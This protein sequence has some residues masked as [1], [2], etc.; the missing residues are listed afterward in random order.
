MLPGMG[1]VATTFIAG[2][3]LARR[4]L[5]APVGS[6]TQMGTIRLGKRTDGQSPLIK[7]LRAR[8]PRWT[9]WCSAAGICSP[10]TPTSG[11]NAEVLTSEHLDLVKDELEQIKPMP[12]V[13]FP[14]FVK[15]LRGENVKKATNKWELAEAVREDIR[16]FK[17]DNGLDRAA[18]RCGAVRP[19]C[20]TEP[21]RSAQLARQVRSRACKRQ[22][23]RHQP[24]D[25]LRLRVLMEDVGYCNGAPNLTVDIPRHSRA[26]REAQAAHLA[27]RTSRPARP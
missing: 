21:K 6:L 3:L 4:G 1:A 15:R 14:E 25:D 23:S 26:R 16:R 19:R 11:R 5:A 22:R 12:A 10:T 17:K 2:C 24:V 18:S 27:A 20:T 7:R 8:S 9:T 13:F